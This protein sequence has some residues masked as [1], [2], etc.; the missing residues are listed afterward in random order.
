MPLSVENFIAVL[1]K[2]GLVESDRL[3]RVLN[4]SA[5]QETGWTTSEQIAQHLVEANLVTKWQAEKLLQGK[6]RG[7]FLGKYKLL[8]LLGKGGMSSVYLA[9]HL[10]MRRHCALK[11][12]PAK[13]VDD[14]SYLERFHREAQAAASLDHPNIVRAYDVDHQDEG[15]R[16]IHFLVM[17]YVEGDSLQEL[18]PESGLTSI[19]DAAEYA[20]QAALGLQHA[21]ENGMVHRDIK[22]GNLLVDRNGVVKILD[23]GL[24]RFFRVDEGNQALT[25]RHDEKVLGTADYLAPE[26][27]I[28]SHNV[29]SRADL[30]SL[31]CTLYFMVTG[32]PPFNEGTLAHRLLAHQVKT[33]PAVESLRV[34]LPLSLAVIIRKMME[35]KPGDRFANA[36]A[37]EKALFQW[38]DGNADIAWRKSHSTVYGS[39]SNDSAT[40]RPVPP[41]ARPIPVAKPVKDEL[42]ERLTPQP[43]FKGPG[44]HSNSAANDAKPKEATDSRF[45]EGLDTADTALD[46]SRAVLTQTTTESETDNEADDRTSAISETVESVSESIQSSPEPAPSNK[47]ENF[48]T[49]LRNDSPETTFPVFETSPVAIPTRARLKSSSKPALKSSSPSQSQHKRS[50]DSKIRSVKTLFGIIAA[51][52]FALMTLYGLWG[53]ASAKKITPVKSSAAVPFPKDKREVTVGN[54]PADYQNIHQALIAV[55]DRFRP[56]L[57]SKDQMVIIVTEGT[58]NERIQIDGHRDGRPDGFPDGVIIRGE[59]KVLLNPPGEDPVIQLANVTRFILEKVEIEAR[60]KRVAI[61]LAGDLHESRLSQILISGFSNSGILCKGTQGLAFSNSQLIL[62]KLQFETANPQAIGIR[63]EE[64]PENDVNNVV[65]RSCRFLGRFDSG[66]VIQG[67]SPYGIEISESVFSACNDGIRIEGSPTLK[68]I[69]VVNNSFRDTKAGIRFLNLPNENSAELFFRRNLFLKTSVAEAVVQMDYDE[70]KFRLMLSIFPPGIE[71]N[72]SDRAK[73]TAPANGEIGILFEQGGQQGVSDLAFESTD[74]K[75]PD[76]LAP[77]SKSRQKEVAGAQGSE[78]KW[79]GAIGP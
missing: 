23:L 6:H 67:K 77:T 31:G 38:V 76:F 28:D 63:L 16:Q 25:L 12:L 17:E 68:S 9:E 79:V 61:E 24:A 46:H 74:P 62:D 4:Q 54:K 29:D 15:N 22:P 78:K 66:I 64:G 19:L 10:L 36:A 52:I 26:Q 47:P 51:S 30:Y 55:R 72:W 20:R 18:V 11:V 59:G 3:L 45:P 27:A 73:P 43:E 70:S 34:D 7:Y 37:I 5:P 14:S 60:E 44:T 13:R 58:Y 39:R 40:A 32:K 33:P 75:S 69:R 1:R 48:E 8:S 53:G 35:K 71:A 2:S 42:S 41:V 50:G 49:T 57:N 56:G 21:H 65:I